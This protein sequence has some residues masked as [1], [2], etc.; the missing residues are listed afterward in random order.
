[1][2]PKASNSLAAFLIVASFAVLIPGVTQDALTLDVS[3]VLPFLGKLNLL[4]ETRGI[5]GT[6]RKLYASGDWPVASLILL[7]SVLIPVGK[8]FILLYV[9]LFPKGP[10][11][12]ALHAFVG[13]ISKWSMA[14]VFVMGI[15]LAYLA[16]NASTGVSAKLH[17][18][19]WYFF[20]YCLLSVLST[21]FIMARPVAPAA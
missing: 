4:H 13:L 7:F 19:F 16:G 15:F 20:A 18:G 10:Y 8:G 9:L 2:S 14:D 17:H 1:M 6:V 3:P 12:A 11:R 5:L 21:H